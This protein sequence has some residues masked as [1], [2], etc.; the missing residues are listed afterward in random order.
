MGKFSK[1]IFDAFDGLS[2]RPSKGSTSEDFAALI[3]RERPGVCSY[4]YA[5]DDRRGNGP[6]AVHYWV[7]PPDFP[8][9]GLDNL[10]VGFKI[11]L[12]NTF[13]SDVDAFVRVARARVE[14]LLPAVPSLTEVVER[15]L[16]TPTALTKRLVAYREQVVLFAAVMAFASTNDTVAETIGRARDAVQKDRPY[17]EFAAECQRLIQIVRANRDQFAEDHQHFFNKSDLMLQTILS[18]H[19]YIESLVPFT[20]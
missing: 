3:R 1:T 17:K 14:S 15:E 9:D 18:R 20:A 13:D 6:L 19:L 7:A 2:F 8:D 11:P 10:G 4:I 16:E 5:R 12:A